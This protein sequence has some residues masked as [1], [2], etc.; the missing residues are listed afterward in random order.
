MARLFVKKTLTGFVPSDEASQEVWS[1]YKLGQVYRAEVVKPRS[2]R[3]H[4]LAMALLTLTF[5]NQERYSD[6]ENFR[7]AVA[8]KAGHVREYVTL[9]GEIVQEADSLSYDRLDEVEFTK[10]FS[11]MMSVCC[12]VLQDIGADELE[13]EVSKYA[14]E[15]Y[16]QVA[17]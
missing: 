9:D 3:H 15:H 13:A 10:V 11:A 4:C 5:Q 14:D 7:K 6:F 2:Y 17:A 12:E 8:R 16:G 1:K